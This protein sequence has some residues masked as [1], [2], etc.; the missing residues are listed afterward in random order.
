MAQS[1]VVV[2]PGAQLVVRIGV[3][4]RPRVQVPTRVGIAEP[5][6]GPDAA[7]HS[8]LIDPSDLEVV[9]VVVCRA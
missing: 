6:K 4:I 2:Q 5:R 3:E 7:H 8:S 1:L 9:E